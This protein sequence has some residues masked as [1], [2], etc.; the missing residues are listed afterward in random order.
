MTERNVGRPWTPEEDALLK[1][2]V[3]LCGDID[4]WKKV[5]ELV[6]GRT[7][8]ACRKRWLHS[9]SPDIKKTAWSPSEDQKLLELFRTH[10]SRW[11]AIARQI[12]GRTDDACSKRYRDALD[13]NL[14]RDEWT[15][16][17][18]AKLWEAFHR[19][20]GKWAQV[21]SVLGRSS[22]G[23]RNRWRLLERKKASLHTR[24]PPTLGESC[25]PVNPDRPPPFPE[26]PAYGGF[27]EQSVEPSQWPAAPYFP[28][29]AYPFP[30]SDIISHKPLPPDMDV[31][32][33][34][35]IHIHAPPVI[36]SFSSLE[37]ALSDPPRMSRPLPPITT[38]YED[39][40]QASSNPISSISP[41]SQAMDMMVVDPIF[42]ES[43]QSPEIQLNDDFSQ[44]IDTQPSTF[45]TEDDTATMLG[46]EPD[47]DGAEP[48]P[49]SPWSSPFPG[50]VNL[51]QQALSPFTNTPNGS[52]GADLPSSAT[53]TPRDVFSP[54]S[55]ASPASLSLTSSPALA[56]SLELPATD[57]VPPNINGPTG[58]LLFSVP[59]QPPEVHTHRHGDKKKRKT[60]MQVRHIMTDTRPQRLS[61]QLRLS[62]E[63]D[64]FP[65]PDPWLAILIY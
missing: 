15:P 43:F 26:P 29:E 24:L 42:D 31:P 32:H 25:E 1:N 21:G 65:C 54:A 57:K 51:V 5:A 64:H 44:V 28:D 3:R 2:S 10:G 52:V 4:N 63:Y 8:K 30:K 61:S 62:K 41:S 49:N 53:S 22:L 55:L 20:G 16:D 19:I 39:T 14:R 37:N 9:L 6:P 13:P 45:Y 59:A 27:Q 34:T 50:D 56:S 33:L 46:F 38:I 60:F 47:A 58:S 7:N 40:P 35:D 17:E 23:C 18:D 11:S 12:P 36:S 48:P